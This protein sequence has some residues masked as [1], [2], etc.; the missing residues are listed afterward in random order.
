MGQIEVIK[1]GFQSTIQDL[2]RFGFRKIGVP[3]SGAMDS[4]SMI[5]ANKIVG[6]PY[7]HPVIEHT[8][9]GGTY[10]FS[11]AVV[12]SVTGATCNP[13]VNGIPKSQYEPIYLNAGD[14]VEL[15]HPSR[16][17]RSY[18]AIQGLLKLSMIMN[19]YSTYLPG[20]FGGFNGRALESGDLLE[21][22]SNLN[23]SSTIEFDKKQIPYFSSKIVLSLNM[24]P[25]SIKVGK[26]V[27][28]KIIS[29][30][31]VVDSNSNR[32]GIRLKGEAIEIRNQEM[33][34][35]PVI[36]GII[37]LPPSGVPIIL[38]K[39]GQTIGGYPR[40]GIFNDSEQ[41]RLGQLKTG[42]QLRF[43]LS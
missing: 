22:Q 9:Y 36:P 43:N 24:G 1:N 27:M 19:S 41:W 17:C 5:D 4:K 38:M 39:D 21:W 8:F 15:N 34:S 26:S 7:S 20:H 40:I 31:Y 10:K 25:E 13:T 35:S 23:E 12:V 14:E 28:E 3:E 30:T 32:M 2:G 33:N 37:Q 29:T 16:G 18:L 11:E 42:D 6:N